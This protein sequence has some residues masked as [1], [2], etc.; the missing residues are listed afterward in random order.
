MRGERSGCYSG[1]APDRQCSF[2]QSHHDRVVVA[3]TISAPH[4]GHRT[5]CSSPSRTASGVGIVRPQAAGHCDIGH[6]DILVLTMTRTDD[7]DVPVVSADRR[8]RLVA[9]LSSESQ[10]IAAES[11]QGGHR[12]HS[13]TT[14]MPT[15]I[16]ALN[17]DANMSPCTAET[18]SLTSRA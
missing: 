3:G 5:P 12:G 17:S 11:I 16:G 8:T 15:M 6:R 14:A 4:V 10:H 2:R 13:N 1:C 7:T 18:L 9:L